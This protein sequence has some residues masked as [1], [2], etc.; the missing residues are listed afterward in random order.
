MHATP[1]ASRH[2]STMLTG[3]ALQGSMQGCR[4]PLHP[5]HLHPST[6]A[7]L[8]AHQSRECHR[9][10]LRGV[11]HQTAQQEDGCRRDV[12]SRDGRESSA[13]THGRK[14]GTEGVVVVSRG[15]GAVPDGAGGDVLG[16]SIDLISHLWVRE[17]QE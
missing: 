2:R 12:I 15:A 8:Q 7:V 11:S 9:R 5:R 13:C 3:R 10:M 1:R 17:A 14:G 4:L 16:R 6:G